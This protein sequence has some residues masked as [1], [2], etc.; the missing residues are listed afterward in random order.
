MK[1]ISLLALFFTLGLFWST[2]QAQSKTT[3]TVRETND[4]TIQIGNLKWIR[5]VDDALKKA[6]KKQ[7]PVLLL[8]VLGHLGGGI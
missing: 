7:K 8:R 3:V 1:K 6:R 4:D 2:L 5:P